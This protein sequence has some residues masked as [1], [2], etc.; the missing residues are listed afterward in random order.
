MRGDTLTLGILTAAAAA[1]AWSRRGARARPARFFLT[2]KPG[3][4]LYHGTRGSGDFDELWPVSW[5][6]RSRDVAAW[7]AKEWR[8][9]GEGGSPKI[10]TFRVTEPISLELLD[11]HD[12]LEEVME[13]LGDPV[14]TSEMAEAFCAQRG[15]GGWIVRHNYGP[16]QDDILLCDPSSLAFMGV[17]AVS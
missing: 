9:E 12:H 1:S 2:L 14:G 6:S 7:F 3:T 16:N 8:G 5:V 15:V 10:L 11:D 4:K 17:E 13:E